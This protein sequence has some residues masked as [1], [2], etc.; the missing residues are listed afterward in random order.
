M[1]I[2]ISMAKSIAHTM[3]ILAIPSNDLNQKCALIILYYGTFA[4]SAGSHSSP[5]PNLPSPTSLLQFYPQIPP[6]LV[7][8]WLPYLKKYNFTPLATTSSPAAVMPWTAGLA[9]LWATSTRRAFEAAWAFGLVASP[10][11][12]VVTY[13]AQDWL[14]SSTRTTLA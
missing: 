8:S 7:P 4:Y 6:T 9:F 12:A 14:C 10:A 5:Y 11:G 1:W 2:T 13:V 3:V